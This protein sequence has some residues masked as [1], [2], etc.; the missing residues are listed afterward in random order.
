[1]MK[2]ETRTGIGL[3]D[4]SIRLV[5]ES[6]LLPVGGF[7]YCEYGIPVRYLKI[8]ENEVKLEISVEKLKNLSRVCENIEQVVDKVVEEL[9]YALPEGVFTIAKVYANGIKLRELSYLE[10]YTS[11][12]KG[13]IIDED[14]ELDQEMPAYVKENRETILGTIREV[15]LLELM[16]SS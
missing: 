14:R 1:M 6:P 3:K 12:G 4:V 8:D 2:E 9:R 13:I 7:V 11:V 16:Y 5:S 15:I 10:E